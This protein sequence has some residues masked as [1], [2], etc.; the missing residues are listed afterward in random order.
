M[1]GI[2][3][4]GVTPKLKDSIFQALESNYGVKLP[5]TPGMDTM[6]CMEAAM[7][8]KVKFGLCLGGNLYG[9]NPDAQYARQSLGRLET[10]VTLSTTM[11][12]GHVHALGDETI[13]LPVLARDEEPQTYDPRVYVQLC[14][15]QRRWT[16][17]D[18]PARAAR[19]KFSQ[20]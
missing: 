6:A 10:L 3:S 18:C 19:Y 12:T 8:G 15:A 17:R 14:A 11:N 1:Q 16:H 2:G 20:N 9:S 5:T 4:I 7:H 13:I